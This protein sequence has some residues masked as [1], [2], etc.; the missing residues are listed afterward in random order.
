[1]EKKQPNEGNLYYEPQTNDANITYT[2]ISVNFQCLSINMSKIRQLFNWI[3]IG[4]K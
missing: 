1:M 2:D 3:S 4:N